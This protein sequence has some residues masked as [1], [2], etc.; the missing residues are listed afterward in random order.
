MDVSPVDKHLIHIRNETMLTF[1]QMWNRDDLSDVQLCCGQQKFHV[2]RFLLAACSPYFQ[3]IFQKN[4][5]QNL[6]IEIDNVQCADLEH[7]LAYMYEGSVLL[8]NDDLQGF[9]E[10]L[11]M[12]MMPLPADMMVSGDNSAEEDDSES[13]EQSDGIT[14]AISALILYYF[15]LPLF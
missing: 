3:A 8:K 6:N 14:I 13:N 4:S 15:L 5:C 7:V 11:E 12:F 9:G 1:K 10:L 2:H